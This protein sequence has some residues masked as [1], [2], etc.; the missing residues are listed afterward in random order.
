MNGNGNGKWDDT[1]VLSI[2]FKL[3]FFFD[4]L[5]VLS[6]LLYPYSYPFFLQVDKWSEY[7]DLICWVT[8]L[9]LN[10]G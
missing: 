8:C 7:T 10:Q 4:L 9:V 2:L 1:M 3:L 5:L 6:L